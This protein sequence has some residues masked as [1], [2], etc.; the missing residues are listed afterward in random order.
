MCRT[1]SC[2]LARATS[3]ALQATATHTASPNSAVAALSRSS[4][5]PTAQP[6]L[7]AILVLQA[8]VQAFG[9]PPIDARPSPAAF[10]T[11]PDTSESGMPGCTT[12]STLRN[13]SSKATPFAPQTACPTLDFQPILGDNVSR[14][15]PFQDCRMAVM[16]TSRSAP[17]LQR[18]AGRCKAASGDG[19]SSPLSRAGQSFGRQ[20]APGRPVTAG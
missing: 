16:G 7:P 11:W 2:C 17:S 9:A 1:R 6:V 5:S 12:W 20:P 4:R 19:R 10:A 15:S 13:S 3:K 18:A 14:Y 8:Q